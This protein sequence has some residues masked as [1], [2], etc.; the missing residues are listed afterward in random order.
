MAKLM[1][2]AEARDLYENEHVPIYFASYDKYEFRFVGE[3]SE[4]KMAATYGGNPKA[5]KNFTT[6]K[7]EQDFPLTFDELKEK[8]FKIHM[9]RHSDGAVYEHFDA[10]VY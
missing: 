3:G 6:D 7:F 8:Y 1:T 4:Y 9:K 10:S 2:D 5:I